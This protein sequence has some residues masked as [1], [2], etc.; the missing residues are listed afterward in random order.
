MQWTVVTGYLLVRCRWC[1]DLFDVSN[2]TD[3]A[4]KGREGSE[5]EA[6]RDVS[7]SED[8]QLSL[9]FAVCEVL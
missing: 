6:E 8:M 9:S 5:A 2:G 1:A 7:L 4:G 3:L